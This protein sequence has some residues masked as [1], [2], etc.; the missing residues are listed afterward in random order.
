[1]YNNIDVSQKRMEIIR[2]ILEERYQGDEI[3]NIVYIKNDT[4]RYYVAVSWKSGKLGD[5]EI[6][7]KEIGELEKQEDIK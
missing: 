3:E 2:R 5:E 1:M 7:Y 4:D 6:S